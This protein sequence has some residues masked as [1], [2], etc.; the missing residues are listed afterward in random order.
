MAMMESPIQLLDLETLGIYPEYEDGG[1]LLSSAV[2]LFE[3]RVSQSLISA[4]FL[5]DGKSWMKSIDA[6]MT[7]CLVR[8]GKRIPYDAVVV[9]V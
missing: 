1:R 2:S 8:C 9:T 7:R 3:A 5:R 4:R 6:T